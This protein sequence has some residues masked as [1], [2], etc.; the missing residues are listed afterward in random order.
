MMNKF[1]CMNDDE[2]EKTHKHTQI[3]EIMFRKCL[4][5]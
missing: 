1:S 3:R 5:R 2:E 4:A